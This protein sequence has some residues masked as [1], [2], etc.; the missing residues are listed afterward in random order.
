MHNSQFSIS[1]HI[2]LNTNQFLVLNKPPGIA[3]QGARDG[4]RTLLD[5]AEIYCKHPLKV[6]H[7]LD[8]VVSGAVVLGKNAR[9]QTAISAQFQNATVHKIYWAI[10][11]QLPPHHEAT[12]RLPL[13]RNPR[14]N[15]S[16]VATPTTS[17][18]KWA[19]LSYRHLSSSDR[20]HLLEIRP[21]TG[22]HHQIRAIMASI[23][24]PIKGDVKYGAR[25]NNPD[26][27]I[28]LHALSLHFTHPVSSE[29]QSATA[30]PPDSPLWSFF[31]NHH[32]LPPDPVGPL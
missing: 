26:R 28:N 24:S 25:R 17:G 12:I 5:L 10:V 11:E 21:R 32:P 15:K 23:G 4:E 19:E 6:I 14:I 31:L 29:P 13:I 9:A 3:V 27:S 18:A 7:R 1:D 2:L 22:R 20:Y 8:R 16:F 30:P